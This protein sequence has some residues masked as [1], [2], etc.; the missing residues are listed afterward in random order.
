MWRKRLM[1]SRVKDR[2]LMYVRGAFAGNF[3]TKKVV[4]VVE[5]REGDKL[6]NGGNDFVINNRRFTKKLAAVYYTMPDAEEF[7]IVLN[8]A[9]IRIRLH[10]ELKPL[11]MIHNLPGC[12]AGLKRTLFRKSLLS[13][14]AFRTSYLFKK[15]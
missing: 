3:N 8:D 4:R 1:K 9:V 14:A 5:R 10:Y 13:K 12:F 6:S 7:G 11:P 2:N 15:P